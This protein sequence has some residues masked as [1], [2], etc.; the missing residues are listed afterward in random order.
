MNKKKIQGNNCGLCGHN[1]V[2][3][4]GN[5]GFLS[6][7]RRAAS[8]GCVFARGLWSCFFSGLGP[9]GKMGEALRQFIML[10]A[11][12]SKSGCICAAARRPAQMQSLLIFSGCGLCVSSLVWV[13]HCVLWQPSMML[14]LSPLHRL[15][16]HVPVTL[17]PPYTLPTPHLFTKEHNCACCCVLCS[18]AGHVTNSCKPSHG[19]LTFS[20]RRTRTWEGAGF[21]S[22]ATR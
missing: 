1:S 5:H 7:H 19:S 15:N 21:N 17:T 18:S 6:S 3:S 11:S 20:Q 8:N 9:R 12:T 2:L 16:Q 4:P 14:R 22:L 13:C 10:S